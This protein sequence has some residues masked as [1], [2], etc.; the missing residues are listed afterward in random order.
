[1]PDE[2]PAEL[3]DM[4][5]DEITL[6]ELG[7]ELADLP[8]LELVETAELYEPPVYEPEFVDP[9]EPVTTETLAD[10][11]RE[12]R[13]QPE[14]IHESDEATASGF[15]A[16]ITG[17][18]PRTTPQ[19]PNGRTCK[20]VYTAKRATRTGFN[21]TVNDW[22][23]SGDDIV[24]WNDGE[25]ASTSA[26]ISGGVPTAHLDYDDDNTDEFYPVAVPTGTPVWIRVEMV[27]DTPVYSFSAIFN[28]IAGECDE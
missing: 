27:S 8:P 20:W 25:V 28:A 7:V 9:P 3:A 21:N 11:A 23:T 16:V 26:I 2:A 6:E 22:T 13:R 10:D 1:M 14:V 4:P 17:N 18:A 5:E 15:R 19:T 24:C 12:Y